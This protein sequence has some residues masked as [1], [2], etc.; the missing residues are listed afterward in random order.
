MIRDPRRTAEEVEK[1]MTNM[2]ARGVDGGPPGSARRI[3]AT[4]AASMLAFSAA[5]SDTVRDPYTHFFQDTFG[6]FTEELEDARESGKKG[7]VIFFEMDEC[8]FCERMRETVLNRTDVQDYYREHFRI[9]TV[10][11][12]GDTEVVDFAGNEMPAKDFAFKVNKVRATPVIAFHDLD[13]RRVVRF[14]GAVRNW[15]EFLW[16]GEFAADG[17][18]RKTNFTRFKRAKR[19]ATE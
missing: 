7:V 14:T 15:Q 2:V 8:P 4:L 3:A 5:G 18:Y 1:V 19:A 17:Y 6:D 12:E 10:D 13:G 9:F 16:L 11:V